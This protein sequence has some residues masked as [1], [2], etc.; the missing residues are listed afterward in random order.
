MGQ[1][2][3]AQKRLRMI[4]LSELLLILDSKYNHDLAFVVFHCLPLSLT[5]FHS[6][7]KLNSV[8]AQI[9]NLLT[10]DCYL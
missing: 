8:Y 9:F 4:L 2:K 6:Q 10:S 3:R 1:R 7:F 5:S